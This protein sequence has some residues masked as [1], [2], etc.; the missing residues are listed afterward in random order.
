M[1]ADLLEYVTI[2]C[3]FHHDT[4]MAIKNKK[5][6]Q[7]E[8]LGSS[9]KACLYDTTFLCLMEARILTSFRAFSFS[10]S[11]RLSIFT[12]F[13]NLISDRTYNFSDLIIILNQ[14]FWRLFAAVI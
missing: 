12:F 5:A 13:K 14:Y 7:S 2:V 6:Y 1:L 8:L 9:K 4:K 3:V 11:E 10:R